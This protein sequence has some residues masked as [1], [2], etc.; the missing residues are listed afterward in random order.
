[1]H[2]NPLRTHW[3]TRILSAGL[4]AA[5]ALGQTPASALRPAQ[6]VRD[7]AS[8]RQTNAGQEESSVRQAL[9]VE[10]TPLPHTAGLEE[11]P[12]REEVVPP[13]GDRRPPE[14]QV[15][16]QHPKGSPRY[17]AFLN[18]LTTQWPV[19]A[20]HTRRDLSGVQTMALEINPAFQTR[21]PQAHWAAATRAEVSQFTAEANRQIMLPAGEYGGFFLRLDGRLELSRHPIDHATWQAAPYLGTTVWT[22]E[23]PGVTHH[24]AGWTLSRFAFISPESSR[25]DAQRDFS[26]L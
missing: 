7:S 10:L 2:P 12:P 17:E 5:L 23:M 21:V 14:L 9:T 24:P 26:N 18:A 4:V 25:R 3:L 6:S 19:T 13:S 22:V 16:L 20:D 1:M 8:L 11:R 15:T